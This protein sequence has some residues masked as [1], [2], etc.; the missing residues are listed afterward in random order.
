MSGVVFLFGAG[1]S[2]GADTVGMP[3]LGAE[4]FGCLQQFSPATW[5]NI[6]SDLAEKFRIDFEAGMMRVPPQQLAPLQRAMADYFFQFLPA[7]SNLYF[8]LVK[9]IAATPN[10]SG[11]LCSLNYERLLEISLLHAGLQPII[12]PML[13]DHSSSIE[14]CLPHG[15]CHLFCDGVKADPRLVSFHGRMA[16][17]DGQVI[18][19]GDPAQ[20]AARVRGDAFP[21]VMSYFEPGKTSPAGRT[22]IARQ[23]ERWQAL[24]TNARTVVIVG[25]RVRPNDA[26]IWEAIAA[27]QARV[28]YSGG[29]QGGAE[30]AAWAN[31]AR[32]GKADRVCEGFFKEEFTRLCEEAGLC[33]IRS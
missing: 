14:L 11:A 32:D 2:S 21:P 13:V 25:V 28:V 5:G 6:G 31:S 22:F 24:A 7:E 17:P 3:P 16:Y 29:R 12:G 8:Q 26:H 30:Y 18:A 9:R 27:S 15:C 20:H 1:A 4:L 33:P 19:I 23:R 10:W